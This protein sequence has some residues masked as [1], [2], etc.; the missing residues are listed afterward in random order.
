MGD[1]NYGDN[2]CLRANYAYPVLA[3]NALSDWA[4]LGQEMAFVFAA[5]TRQIDYMS[6]FNDTQELPDLVTIHAGGNED[7]TLDELI[8]NC[9]IKNRRTILR[10]LASAKR[11]LT[12]LGH[13]HLA[14]HYAVAS[15]LRF[16][17]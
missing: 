2:N 8:E 10:L 4:P 13:T 7:S 12:G 17:I 11:A 3:A 5:C 6:R 15:R 16:A 9:R 1:T 14:T